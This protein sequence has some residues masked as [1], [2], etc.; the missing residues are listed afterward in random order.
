MP[1]LN[2]L[3]AKVDKL[4]TCTIIGDIKK[5]APVEERT[6]VEVLEAASRVKAYSPLTLLSRHDS[7][8]SSSE[9]IYNTIYQH[10][11]PKE[12]VSRIDVPVDESIFEVP[13]DSCASPE[14]GY[15]SMLDKGE[16]CNNC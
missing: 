13:S 11:V 5:K 16:L 2:Y 1:E 3:P 7:T 12:L 10:V 15:M 6:A 8:S 14:S 4:N 9:G